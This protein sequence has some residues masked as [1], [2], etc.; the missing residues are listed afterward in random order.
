MCDRTGTHPFAKSAKGWATRVLVIVLTLTRHE[1]S[2]YGDVYVS[3][4]DGSVT[5]PIYLINRKLI[6]TGAGEIHSLVNEQTVYSN[7]R[8]R[9]GEFDAAGIVPDFDVID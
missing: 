8:G 1:C 5:V 4:V 7:T 3:C 2:L 6:V 9:L